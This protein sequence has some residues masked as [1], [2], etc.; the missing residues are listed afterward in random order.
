MNS[1]MRGIDLSCKIVAPFVAGLAMTLG[2]PVIGAFFIGMGGWPIGP[3]H[4]CAYSPI[5][6]H[7]SMISMLFCGRYLPSMRGA[8]I[9]SALGCII[10]S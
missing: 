4:G 9:T 7:T 2:S 6:Q 10:V 5:V 3:E 1:V 8:K